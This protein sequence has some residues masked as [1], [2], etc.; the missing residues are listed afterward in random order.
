M[1]SAA[2]FA[3]TWLRDFRPAQLKAWYD[4]LPYG[5]TTEKL[6]MITRAGLQPVAFA[7]ARP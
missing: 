2:P 1:P 3:R 5:R 6:L 7:V 4:G